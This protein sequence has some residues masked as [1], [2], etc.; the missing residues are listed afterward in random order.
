MSGGLRREK[1]VKFLKR[2]LQE[3]HSAS[4]APFDTMRLTVA[5]FAIS[6]LDLLNALDMPRDE[7]DAI[8]D[9]IYSLEVRLPQDAKQQPLP[10][11]A[12]FRGSPANGTGHSLDCGHLAMTYS[13]LASLLILGDDLSRVDKQGILRSL[14]DLQLPSGSFNATYGSE[15]DMRFVF[16]ATTICYILRDWSGM[17]TE[18]AVT[19]IKNS[20]SYEGAFGQGPGLEAHGGSTF[21]A[22]ASLILMDK[23][24]D[25]LS[26]GQISRLKRWCLLK[27]VDG[28]QGRPNKPPDTCYSFWIGATLQM[29]GAYNFVNSEDNLDFVLSTQDRLMGGLAKYPDGYPDALHTYLGIAGLSLIPAM[30]PTLNQVNSP[31]NITERAADH[32]KRLHGNWSLSENSF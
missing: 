1:Q 16:C 13:A 27:Q 12:G 6:G 23:L 30:S 32:L 14:R 25:T 8:I 22:V 2:C 24:N 26:V 4:A 7:K 21:C 3:E 9:W 31:L 28:F 15:S 5:F 29:L 18:N 19:F 11:V 17:N 20:W 10:R